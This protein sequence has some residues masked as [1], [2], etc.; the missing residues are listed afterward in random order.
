M[1]KGQTLLRKLW[2]E[3]SRCAGD[4]G[5]ALGMLSARTAAPSLQDGLSWG[6]ECGPCTLIWAKLSKDTT[7]SVWARGERCQP[8]PR[9]SRGIAGGTGTSGVFTPLTQ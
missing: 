4:G 6:L 8:R 3:R 9:L 5:P 2:G 7:I 1:A